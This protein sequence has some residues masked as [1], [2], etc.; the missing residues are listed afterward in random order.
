M[1]TTWPRPGRALRLDEHFGTVLEP[2]TVLG[3][4]TRSGYDIRF[5]DG[6]VRRDV[7][8]DYVIVDGAP[9]LRG[10]PRRRAEHDA[11]H[12]G[13]EERERQRRKLAATGQHRDGM[14]VFR[15]KA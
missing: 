1:A 11:R 3:P 8:T 4:G 14:G 2:V 13:A 12:Q 15:K 5:A 10:R 7:H 9:A 6:E